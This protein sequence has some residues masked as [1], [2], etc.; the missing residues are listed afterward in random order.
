MAITQ[1]Y[2][3]LLYSRV[4]APRGERFADKMIDDAMADLYNSAQLDVLRRAGKILRS[5]SENAP[6]SGSGESR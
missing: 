6:G 3:G 4:D 2:P 5:Q 1:A